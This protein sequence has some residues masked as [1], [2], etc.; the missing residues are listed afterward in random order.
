VILPF[1]LTFLACGPKTSPPAPAAPVPAPVS[2][3]LALNADAVAGVSDP[4]LAL[5]LHDQWEA[6]LERS[7]VWATR[8]G[9]HRFDDRLRD[10]S[11]AA[12]EA[13][14]AR[15]RAF[16]M[17]I[18]GIDAA[19]LTASDATTLMLFR[20]MVATDIAEAPCRFHAWSLSPR[21]NALV[22]VYDL[23]EAH[24]VKTPADAANLLA[25]YRAA[26]A[27]ILAEAERLKRGATE[28]FTA[29]AETV[30]RTLAQATEALERPVDES[31]LLHVLDAEVPGWA[32]DER[33]AWQ[34]SVRREV[35]TQIRPALIAWRDAVQEGVL[36]VARPPERA[37]LR[38][39][40]DGEACYGALVHRY[41]TLDRTPEQVH[42]AGLE[43]IAAVHA[44]LVAL[45]PEALGTADLAEIF[46]SLR[47]EPSIR[48]SDAAAVEAAAR[49]ALAAAEAA[50]P[51]AIG[52]LPEAQCEVAAIPAHEA[53]YTTIAY[54][55]PSEPGGGRPGVYYVN[56]YAPET[57]PRHEA[58]VLAFHE[59]VPGHHLQ[60]ALAQ[61]LPELPA[62]R[63]H[64][65]M[66]AFVEGW[67]LYSER[68]ADELGLYPT[69]TDRL[70]MLSFDAWRASR[71]VVDTG[72]H[73]M[74]W[75]R[76]QAED[77]MRENTP[78]ADNNIVN[79]VDRY[80]SWPGQA[81]AYKTG[82]MEI[83]AL[84]AQAEAALGD[85]FDRSGFHDAVLGS[86]AVSLPILRRNVEAWIS[87]TQ[88]GE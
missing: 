76:T 25:R 74:G 11:W 4:A 69:P 65:G 23:P 3:S 36:P 62:F 1:L 68:L 75:T 88:A 85:R 57:R 27:V 43:A 80:V 9:D 47:E 35:E 41:T 14:L 29:P 10:A 45:G 44:E 86:G 77:W 82:Q 7:P 8:L 52:H 72:V 49:E 38:F 50:V 46:E 54:Y 33:A 30:R 58:R 70:G 79:E 31:P 64:I 67:A 37:G 78:L 22:D 18:D 53:P 48:F 19:E 40:P 73:H 84:R 42:Q 16:Q 15:N 5:L 39:L 17:R 59:S 56:T 66:T 28:G 21:F 60:I 32:E 6:T 13:D 61:E 83:L 24:A 12:S 87:A 71:L 20:E 63:R 34:L 51:A 55:Q 81:V 2:A 26:P